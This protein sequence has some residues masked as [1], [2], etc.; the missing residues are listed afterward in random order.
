[1]PGGQAEN[2]CVLRGLD[3]EQ[4]VQQDQHTRAHVQIRIYPNIA[5]QQDD[6]QYS[7]ENPAGQ[8]VLERQTVEV[9]RHVS[10]DLDDPIAQQDNTADHAGRHGRKTAWKETGDPGDVEQDRHNHIAVPGYPKSVQ[11]LTSLRVIYRKYNGPG[12]SIK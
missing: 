12:I 2:L 7:E 5:G 9:V 11:C 6:P 10:D 8:I 1:M 3:G 4:A